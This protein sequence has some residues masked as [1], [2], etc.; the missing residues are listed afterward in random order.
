MSPPPKIAISWKGKY[1]YSIASSEQ[2]SLS[3]GHVLFSPWHSDIPIICPFIN[4]GHI[5]AIGCL[6]ALESIF[7]NSSSAWV[8]TLSQALTLIVIW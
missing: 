5:M 7:G 6:F 1:G 8:K 4:H 3:N 2:C